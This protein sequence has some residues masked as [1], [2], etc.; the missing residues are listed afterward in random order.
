MGPRSGF[1]GPGAVRTVGEYCFLIQHGIL[2]PYR[3]DTPGS[4]AWVPGVSSGC[5]V[6]R[7][8]GTVIWRSGGFTGRALGVNVKYE[9]KTVSYRGCITCRSRGRAPTSGCGSLP[10]FLSM[11]VSDC[12]ARCALDVRAM[13]RAM[14]DD[15]RLLAKRHSFA[16]YGHI[17]DGL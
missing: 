5:A 2:L 8:G 14:S 13:V 3:P 10:A 6:R 7:A 16:T 1:L 17:S 4:P 11:A 15:V 12:A 9:A